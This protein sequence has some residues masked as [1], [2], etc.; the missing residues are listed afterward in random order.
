MKWTALDW[1]EARPCVLESQFLGTLKGNGQ[2]CFFILSFL[3]EFP[4][5]HRQ[6]LLVISRRA[7]R[8]S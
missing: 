2:K 1:E 8:I 4:P 6:L 7:L 5:L 3:G